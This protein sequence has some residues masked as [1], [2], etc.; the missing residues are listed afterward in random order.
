MKSNCP[1]EIRYIELIEDSYDKGIWINSSHI[2]SLSWL[3]NHSMLK[4]AYT[5]YREYYKRYCYA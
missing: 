1:L 5:S 2:Y 4:S 3:E